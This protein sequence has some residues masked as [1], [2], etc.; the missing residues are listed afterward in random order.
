MIP[1]DYGQRILA[2]TAQPTAPAQ[3]L[4][5]VAW[6]KAYAEWEDG[7]SCSPSCT[8]LL[9]LAHEIDPGIAKTDRN[10]DILFELMCDSWELPDLAAYVRTLCIY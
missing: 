10:S 6:Q 2:Y 5:L 1:D 4:I 8:D 7:L 3:D 9:N